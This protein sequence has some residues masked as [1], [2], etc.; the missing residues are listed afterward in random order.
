MAILH[1]KQGL[2][3]DK[4]LLYEGWCAYPSFPRIFF[5]LIYAS[6][7]ILSKSLAAFPYTCNYILKEETAVRGT[8]SIIK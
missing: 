1:W 6:K 8:N 2:L 7:Y 4:T 3:C 5:P